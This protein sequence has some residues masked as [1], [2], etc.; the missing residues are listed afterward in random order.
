MVVDTFQTSHILKSRVDGYASQQSTICLVDELSFKLDSSQ[1]AKKPDIS[2]EIPSNKSDLFE[3]RY[4]LP[5]PP[6]Y[7]CNVLDRKKTKGRTV[8]ELDVLIRVRIM[9]IFPGLRNVA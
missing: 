8:S 1:S 6:A 9:K 7:V 3:L 2:F 5:Y 4:F